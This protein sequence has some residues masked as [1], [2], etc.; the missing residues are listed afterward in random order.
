[1]ASDE[2]DIQ[3]WSALLKERR[4]AT[5]SEDFINK[6]IERF[7]SAPSPSP[8]SHKGIPRWALMAASLVA[9]VGLAFATTVVVEII[10][11]WRSAPL[12]LSQGESELSD[13]FSHGGI[14]E[15]GTVSNSPSDAGMVSS[16]PSEAGTF[17]GSPSKIEGVAERP[18]EYEQTTT[19]HLLSANSRLNGGKA[20]NIKQK[21]ALAAAAVTVAGVALPAAGV[22]SATS[23]AMA[24]F[25]SFVASRA[26]TASTLEDGFHS[27]VAQTIETDTLPQFNSRQPR[28]MRIVIQ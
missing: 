28:G 26:Q 27:F 18:G 3:R 8:M 2:D 16:S 11:P 6:T 14:A 24:S 19:D 21:A 4:H 12:P 1:M 7:R 15:V 17:S 13:S 23:G 10:P 22:A 25:S 5:L 20:M 9:M